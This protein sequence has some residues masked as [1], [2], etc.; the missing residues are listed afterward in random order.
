MIASGCQGEHRAGMQRLARNEY[1]YLALKPDDKVLFSARINSF[2]NLDSNTGS[3]RG[4]G[5]GVVHYES[6]MTTYIGV[7]MSRGPLP[8]RFAVRR[9]AV[10]ELRGYFI[11]SPKVSY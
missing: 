7:C 5:W 4:E 8:F 2:Q 11:Q 6:S 3:G 10:P 1:K 9:P